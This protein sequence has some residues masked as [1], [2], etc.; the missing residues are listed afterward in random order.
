MLT[1]SLLLLTLQD[2]PPLRESDSCAYCTRSVP[3][4]ADKACSS[5]LLFALTTLCFRLTKLHKNLTITQNHSKGMTIDSGYHHVVLNQIFTSGLCFC[6]VFFG[7]ILCLR[8]T[9][10]PKILL[11]TFFF[12]LFLYFLKIS[13]LFKKQM[14]HNVVFILSCNILYILFIFL[15]YL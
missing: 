5:W 12:W 11:V 8:W 10:C 2:F 1:A 4:T 7:F 3:Q 6:F 15:F 13:L 9:F 14:F